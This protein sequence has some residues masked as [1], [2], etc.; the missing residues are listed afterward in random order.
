MNK[1]VQKGIV[2]AEKA[3]IKKCKQL[4]SNIEK[5]VYFQSAFGSI[6]QTIQLNR[7]KANCCGRE[8]RIRQQ[9][10]LS[11]DPITIA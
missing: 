3:N 2:M 7:P 11:I 8:T 10:G 6:Q 5:K 9:K 1:I 4:V